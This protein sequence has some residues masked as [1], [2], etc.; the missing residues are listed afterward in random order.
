MKA[1]LCKVLL[2]VAVFG[3]VGF[4]KSPSATAVVEYRITD[5]GTLGGSGSSATDINNIGEIV[6]GS[7]TPSGDYHA[8]FWTAEGEIYDLGTLGGLQSCAMGMN[9]HGQVVGWSYTGPST[10]PTRAF[11]WDVENGMKNLGTLPGC[12]H[13]SANDINDIGQIVGIS[14]NIEGMWGHACLWSSE[15]EIEDLGTLGGTV[16]VSWAINNHGQVA[17]GSYDSEG[18]A[19]VFLWTAEDGMVGI[20]IPGGARGINDLGQIV[21]GRDSNVAFLW[22]KDG[23]A[24]DLCPGIAYDINNEGKIVGHHGNGNTFPFLWDSISGVQ[25]LNSFVPVDAG[26]YLMKASAINDAGQIGGVG[27]VDLDGDGNFDEQH[28]FL[29]T[30]ISEPTIEAIL[31]F[32]DESVEDGTLE[33]RGRGWFAKLRLL[34]MRTMLVIAGEFIEQGEVDKACW[35]L[36]RAHK[37]CDGEPWPRDFVVG[38]AVPVL[39]DMIDTLMESLGCE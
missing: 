27:Q 1:N 30:P 37:R 39:A 35:V 5:L 2:A 3:M 28:A 20:G 17:G 23:G 15:G 7:N 34:L 19:Q 12:D 33:G 24:V 21:G 32:F 11:I 36:Q 10:G 31:A 22:S 4:L 8:C 14:D 13:S 16:S 38:E 6:G 29:L 26:W 9:D 18:A 25:D